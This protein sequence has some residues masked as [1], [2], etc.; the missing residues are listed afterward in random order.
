VAPGFDPY[1][2]LGVSRDATA[3]QIAQARRRLSRQYHPDVNPATD[4]AA[5]FDEVQRAFNLLADPAA[6]SAYDHDGRPGTRRG[7]GPRPG[8]GT[9]KPGLV[10]QPA[11]VDFGRL[12]P[13]RPEAY[14]KVT[15]SWT[16]AGAGEITRY[17]RGEWWKTVAS[18]VGTHSGVA[19][20]DLRAEF[21]P[22]MPAGPQHSEFTVTLGDASV[23][24][25]LTAEFGGPVQ[26]TARGTGSGADAARPTVRER[27][28]W[29]TVLPM[30]ILVVLVI[31]RII[32]LYVGGS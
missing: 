1:A 20:F 17:P 3:D 24:V 15:V 21:R 7:P 14:A 30:L 22:G 12:G 10:A 19:L 8:P 32:F 6:R 29:M 4:A 23:T 26:P 28:P 25:P 13:A 31:I 27:V 2:V 18:A 16:G 11:A 5:R 9:G